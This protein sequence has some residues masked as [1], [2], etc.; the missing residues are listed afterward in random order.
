MKLPSLAVWLLGCSLPVA[1]AGGPDEVCTDP[2]LK[3]AIAALY[4]RS[5]FLSPFQIGIRVK[6]ARVTLEGAVSD[7][8]ELALAEEIAAGVEGISS[9]VNSIRVDPSASQ[10]RA[11]G[12]PAECLT[13]DDALADRAKT[14]LRWHRAT[15]GMVVDVSARDGVVTLRGQAAS[16]QQ[17]ELARLIVLNTC[18]V[19][20]V[21]SQLQMS[22]ER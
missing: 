16:P 1:V 3:A 19:K 8:S 5:P 6:D 21:D 20:R 17:A 2:C 11:I 9:V 22:R 14:Q 4:I 10:Q 15:H 7:P 18:G 13:D 12:P